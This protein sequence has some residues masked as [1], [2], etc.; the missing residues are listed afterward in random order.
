MSAGA[1]SRMQKSLREAPWQL[2]LTQVGAIFRI[3]IRKNLWRRRSIWIY[4]LAF[5]PTV[6]FALGAMMRISSV[7]SA[8]TQL[9]AHIFQVFYLRVGIFFGCMGLFTWLFRGEIVEKSLHY[10]FLAPVRRPVLI[11]GKFLA[12]LFTMAAVF[13]LSVL[14]GFFF[15]YSRSGADGRA[16]MFSG[17]GL[18][19]LMSYLL[20]TT[21]ACLGFGSIFLALSLVFKNPILPG[22]VVLLWETFHAAAPALLQK[23][24]VSF[25]LTQLCPVTMPQEGFLT[26]FTVLAEPVSPWLAIYGLIML[27][28]ATL[29]FACVRIQRTEINYL[30]D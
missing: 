30:A 2:W 12:G 28:V 16:F 15:N 19:H 29:V 1:V 22:I 9:F 25:Y 8:D 24:S 17:P 26:L 3:E 23:L 5:A 27:S 21:L 14:L 4:L 6:M 11:F 13:N 18:G 10:Y 7:V 20:V